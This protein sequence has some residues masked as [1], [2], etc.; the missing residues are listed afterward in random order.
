MRKALNCACLAI[1]LA[2]YTV[3]ATAQSV[4]YGPGKKTHCHE[5]DIKQPRIRRFRT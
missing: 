4:P 3:T 1:L 5:R 2:T